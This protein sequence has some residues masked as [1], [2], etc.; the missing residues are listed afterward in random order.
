MMNFLIKETKMRLTDRP[1]HKDYII[2]PPKTKTPK[3]KTPKTNKPKAK[4]SKG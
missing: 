4:T 2:K 1:E 3:V